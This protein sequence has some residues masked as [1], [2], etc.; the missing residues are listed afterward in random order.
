MSDTIIEQ[1]VDPTE[2]DIAQ[3][4]MLFR[5]IPG[6]TC[7][8]KNYLA[9]LNYGWRANIAVFVVRKDGKIVGFAQATAPGLL[10]PT[11]AWLPFSHSTN[12]CGR[13]NAKKAVE[14]AEQWMQ[15]VT[16]KHRTGS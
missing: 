7:S 3:V 8:A 2:A 5:G 11:S 9:Y 13:K 12:K 16:G 14:L 15:I 4:L 6:R 1:L 10:D